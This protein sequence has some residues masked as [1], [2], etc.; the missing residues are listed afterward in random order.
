MLPLSSIPPM[1]EPAD[2]VHCS[3][4][5]IGMMCAKPSTRASRKVAFPRTRAT[6]SWKRTRM[7]T[8]VIGCSMTKTLWKI[9]DAREG[10][11]THHDHTHASEIERREA[12][13]QELR[14][15]HLKSSTF[16]LPEALR[17]VEVW[18]TLA[19][20][21]QD[22]AEIEWV[23]LL[24]PFVAP[25]V[26]QHVRWCQGLAVCE[27]HFL[28]FDERSAVVLSHLRHANCCNVCAV[29]HQGWAATVET[30]M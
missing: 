15:A 17:R 11:D 12:V 4:T 1:W 5:K 26:A 27:L 2:G 13:R 29:S 30:K 18:A 3:W 25:F 6:S 22:G 19:L 23:F 8:S 10:C 7:S 28:V 24:S 9:R 20:R 21:R 14:S 16:A